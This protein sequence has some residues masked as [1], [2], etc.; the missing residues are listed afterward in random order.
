MDLFHTSGQE[1]VDAQGRGNGWAGARDEGASLFLSSEISACLQRGGMVLTGNA[2]AAR[3]LDMAYTETRRRN[4]LEAWV[5]PRI[6]DWSA[7]L[8]TLWNQMLLNAGDAPLLLTALKEHTV[9]KDIAERRG[10]ADLVVSIDGMA[11]QAQYAFG[12]LNDY[13]ADAALR[14]SWEYAGSRDTEAFRNW[15]L[16]F[17]EICATQKW[18]SRSA[19][20][21]T[22]TAAVL[23][24]QLDVPLEILLIG[25]DRLLPAQ[26]RLLAALETRKTRTTVS[27]QG[28]PALI[29]TPQIVEAKDRREELAA[30]AFWARN[31]LISAPHSRI[32][33]F[34][35][36]GAATR[37]EME[38]SFRRVLL[39][40]SL[41]IDAATAASPYEFSLG[42]P[43]A[44]TP[45]VRAALLLLRWFRESL[46]QEEVSWILLS[47]FIG[48]GTG[49]ILSAAQFDAAMRQREI[50]TPEVS[51]DWWLNYS[52]RF[53]NS[54]QSPPETRRLAGRLL[55]AQRRAAQSIQTGAREGNRNS[56][57]S[58][59]EWVELAFELLSIAGWPGP[60]KEDSAQFQARKKFDKMTDSVAALGFNGRPVDY[61]AF[62][63]TMLH[64][65]ATT[66]FQPQSS[67]APIQIMGP[68]EAAG[69][70]F[71]ACW[72]LSID[73]R[74]WPGK[75]APHP[76]LPLQLQREYKMPHAEAQID[77]E[78]ALQITRRVAACS[79]ECIFSYAKQLP[80]G[81]VN[82]S[83]VLRASFSALPGTTPV[84]TF[85]DG[86]GP[87]NAV[88]ELQTVEAVDTSAVPWPITVNAGGTEILKM[89][90]ACPFKAFATRRLGA[91]ELDEAERG[92]SARD[93]GIILHGI[94]QNIF[95]GGNKPQLRLQTSEDLVDAQAQGRIAAII[96]HHVT[97]YIDSRRAS[98]DPWQTAYLNSEKERLCRLLAEWL[99]KEAQRL[100]FAVEACERKL[101]DVRVGE[102]KLNLRIDRIDKLAAGGRVLIDYKSAKVTK[103]SWDGE[104]PDEPQLPLYAAFGNVDELQGVL[105][106]QLRANELAFVGRVRDSKKTF[107]TELPRGSSTDSFDAQVREGWMPSLLALAKGF[108]DG[109]ASVDPKKY[110]K[111]CEHCPLPTLCRVADTPVPIVA[112]AVDEPELDYGS[113]AEARYE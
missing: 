71:D 65:A 7:F 15:A 101:E 14:R 24:G 57:R 16:S 74:H 55:H 19:L 52:N 32:G 93:R 84:D 97:D 12:L 29:P 21:A 60:E 34:V 26:R 68:M 79:R 66:I 39:P 99:G 89:Q 45:A 28:D 8:S 9:W 37:A 1:F 78:L 43:L 3:A 58:Y 2:R 38:R 13:E 53:V 70:E 17:E 76:L 100:P 20:S 95:S 107:Q 64:T 27:T 63:A 59:S 83:P 50:T 56:Q 73:D 41:G 44:A 67:N 86:K 92:L 75:A 30:C 6:A 22:V 11:E 61:G 90:A 113:G 81:A 87:P 72:F 88:H 103:S 5:A 49:Q 51:L 105:Y 10:D 104:R 96:E 4:G 31:K 18:I 109:D 110:P 25:F 85:F 33:I 80:D 82:L 108:V 111:T 48:D 23:A 54:P 47:G 106:A 40:G 36:D 69:Q 46:T 35:Q 94:L 42:R 91:R 98:D 77:W 102:L 62:I 112:K